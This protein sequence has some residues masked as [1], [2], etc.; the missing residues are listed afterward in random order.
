VQRSSYVILSYKIKHGYDIGEFLNSYKHLLQKAID[1]IWEY[2]EWIE[3]K[4]RNYYLIKQ[5]RRKIRKYYYVKR[6]IPVIPPYRWMYD[7]K[8]K[9][10]C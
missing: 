9:D 10:L 8:E 6:L 3:K 2:M 1:T 4:Q 5:G 7:G